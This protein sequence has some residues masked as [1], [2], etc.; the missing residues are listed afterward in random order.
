MCDFSSQLTDQPVISSRDI[1]HELVHF[2]YTSHLFPHSTLDFAEFPLF[3]LQDGLSV[4]RAPE[5]GLLP[6]SFNE[7]VE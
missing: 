6:I 5:K 2:N 4:R 3:P 1:L 7:L